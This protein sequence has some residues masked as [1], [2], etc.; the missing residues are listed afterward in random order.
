MKK[1]W[2]G[3]FGLGLALGISAL[4]TAAMLSDTAGI[5]VRLDGSA[6]TFDIVVSGSGAPGWI[7]DPTEWEQGDAIPFSLPG[8]SLAPGGAAQFRIAVKNASKLAGRISMKVADGD[9]KG[10]AV[11]P[12]GRFVELFD[13]LDFTVKSDG[14]TLVDHTPGTAVGTVGE[15]F[16]LGPGEYRVFDVTLG[17]PEELDNR[18][19]DA[20]TDVLF[21]FE[22]VSQ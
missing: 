19:M 21:R 11:N 13:Q 12:A 5:T 22:G 3:V 1:V 8:S 4:P 10:A 14:R 7:P 17:L 6:N 20:R 2:R 18:W 16:E 15:P 9:P